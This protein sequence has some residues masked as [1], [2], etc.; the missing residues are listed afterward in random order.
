LAKVLAPGRLDQPIQ[1]VVGV[2]GG[3]FDAL[4]PEE[5]RLLRVGPGRSW[6]L[7][8]ESYV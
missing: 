7:P 1:G 4:V 6:M 3:W 2:C 8:I 5:D